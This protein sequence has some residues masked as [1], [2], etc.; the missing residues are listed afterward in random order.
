[1]AI[2]AVLIWLTRGHAGTRLAAI[3]RLRINEALVVPE[4]NALLRGEEWAGKSVYI[5]GVPKR[6]LNTD[7][8]RR[9]SKRLRTQR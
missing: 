4:L 8:N 9:C 1:M 3:D 7:T 6:A 5:E 2:C